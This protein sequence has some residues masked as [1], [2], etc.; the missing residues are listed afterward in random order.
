MQAQAAR[1]SLVFT[2]RRRR[3]DSQSRAPGSNWSTTRPCAGKGLSI[4]SPEIGQHPIAS[5][6]STRAPWDPLGGR[7]RHGMSSS[8]AFFLEYAPHLQQKKSDPVV[9]TLWR[10][11]VL[12]G[13]ALIAAWV[14][15]D[16]QQ[17]AHRQRPSFRKSLWSDGRQALMNLSM[18]RVGRNLP[19]LLVVSCP[20]SAALQCTRA[21]YFAT[22]VTQCQVRAHRASARGAWG[23]L[24]VEV[25]AAASAK[26]FAA[27]STAETRPSSTAALE[28]WAL[29]LV[30][31]TAAG[32][33]RSSMASQI[34]LQRS[35]C[36]CCA[37]V[38]AAEP[39]LQE[40]T[41]HWQ[42]VWYW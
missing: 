28:E 36:T 17:W 29:T 12:Q 25:F 42:S 22:M 4:G 9:C 26:S 8:L 13:R 33:P 39:L 41:T 2:F 10:L 31:W 40:L 27:L 3:P 1:G 35:A 34:F 23:C 16:L 32:P 15:A 7:P 37:P 18:S 11:C 5:A 38:Q 30:T 14:R 21:R 24:A 20:A 19:D 6:P